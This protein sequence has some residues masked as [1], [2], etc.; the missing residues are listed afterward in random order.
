MLL[1]NIPG[2]SIGKMS[3]YFN[4]SNVTIQLKHFKGCENDSEYFNTSNVTIQLLSA[5]AVLRQ[6]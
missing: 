5:A 6:V 1:F 3:N 4:T 2:V